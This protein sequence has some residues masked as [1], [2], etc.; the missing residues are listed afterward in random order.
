MSEEDQGLVVMV[1]GERHAMG[2]LT[3][4]ERR[5]LRRLARELEGDPDKEMEDVMFD[6]LVAAF[7]TVVK[8]RT[9]PEFGIDDALDFKPSDLV[10]GP[11]DGV[12]K[13]RPTRA[14]AAGK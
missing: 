13:P 2:D 11:D 7:A 14:K 8:Q 4:R 12:K 1:D 3:F 10:P 5:E 9:H 6:Y